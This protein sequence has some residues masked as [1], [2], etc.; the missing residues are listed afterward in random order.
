MSRFVLLM[1]CLALA[2]R[3]FAEQ[4]PHDGQTIGY[5]E[6]EEEWRGEVIHLSWSPRAFV[7][8]KFLSDE[9]CDYLVGKAEP[10]M[11]ESGVVDN[12]TGHSKKSEVRTS[13]GTFFGRGQDEVI[14]KIE[15]RVAQV[16]MIPVENQ[17]GLQVLHYKDGQK[18]EPHYDYFHD[19]L[20]QRPENGGQ[21]L[22]TMLM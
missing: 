12:D 3:A 18:Y 20:N 11:T 16:T 21:R 19:A 8:K 5:G 14:T 17:E 22:V 1:A 6:L 13:T 4:L 2:S 7:V 15:K 10:M 9:E